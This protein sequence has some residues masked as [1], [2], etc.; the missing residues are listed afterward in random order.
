MHNKF[1]LF[2]FLLAFSFWIIPFFLR[3]FVVDMSDITVVSAENDD[4]IVTEVVQQLNEGNNHRA[5]MLVLKN[6][7]LG[8]V[9][10]ILGGV[11]LGLLTLFNLVYNGFFM[12]DAFMHA[13]NVVGLD[14]GL[15]LKLFLPH[16]FELIGFWMS[17]AV[18]FYIAWNII[19]VMLDKKNIAP[20]FYKNVGISFVII[21]LIISL[22][23]YMEVYVSA[24]FV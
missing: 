21:V 20:Y 24:T 15:L 2:L 9:V 18:G 17:G 4:T 23:A 3:V 12:A 6:N 16:S 19:Q 22:A 5:F 1:R 10:N 13:Y 8:C 14:T 7:L 11:L